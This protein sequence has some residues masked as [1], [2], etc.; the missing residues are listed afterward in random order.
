MSDNNNKKII[1]MFGNHAMLSRA[2]K[3]TEEIH[4]ILQHQDE[5]LSKESPKK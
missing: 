2:G 5:I 1:N 3:F 4:M